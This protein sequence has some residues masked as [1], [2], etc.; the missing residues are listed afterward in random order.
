MNYAE[1]VADKTT[2]NSICGWLNWDKAPAISI[3]SEAESAIYSKLR[4][5][6]MEALDEGTISE[7]D[8]ELELPADFIA[9]I[10]FRRVGE[11]MGK[12]IVLDRNHFEERLS[13][14]ENGEFEIGPPTEC[15]IYGY[16]ATAHFNTTADVDTDYRLLYYARPAALSVVN[17]TNW[18]TDTYP[19]VVRSV[20]LWLGFL[21]KKEMQA[22]QM[23]AGIAASLLDA[24]NGN[25]D[26][27]QAL[28][29]PSCS[30]SSTP[31]NKGT[32]PWPTP[33]PLSSTF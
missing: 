7:A 32:H 33:I 30:S 15:A 16:P 19:L 21:Y 10:S 23:W 26:L 14:D 29:Q 25:G 6:E 28:V 13:L 31:S 18:L 5:S 20:C 12:I 22:A 3:L 24:V 17:Q 11:A 4:V 2:Q 8:S 9:P 27:A 1:M